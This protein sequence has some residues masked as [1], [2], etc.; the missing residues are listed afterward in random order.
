MTALIVLQSFTGTGLFST[1]TMSVTTTDSCE[2]VSNAYANHLAQLST[3]SIPAIVNGYESNATVD[4]IGL[5]PGMTANSSGIAGNYSG[6]SSIAILTGEFIA[7]LANFS[8]A[9]D[10][11]V[12]AVEP[13]G[14]V[15]VNSTFNFRGYDAV[16]GNINGTVV[17]RD[18]YERVGDSSW[19][20]ARETW[21]FTQFQGQFPL[22]S[23]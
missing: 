16:G 5:T 11:Q 6:S 12:L 20:I 13:N 8:L 21:D 1:R 9:N 2:Q 15:V 7:R 19:L 23:A 4:W 17:A 18:M 14:S 22:V 3:R 10:S